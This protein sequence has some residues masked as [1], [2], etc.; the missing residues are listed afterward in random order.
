MLVP[1]GVRSLIFCTTPDLWSKEFEVVNP[2]C[3]QSA[4]PSTVRL[5]AV[6]GDANE[7]VSVPPKVWTKTSTGGD[8]RNAPALSVAS[9]VIVCKPTGGLLQVKLYAPPDPWPSL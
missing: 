9:A 5:T 2:Q 3:A 4:V 1:S 7:P 6:A 8:K